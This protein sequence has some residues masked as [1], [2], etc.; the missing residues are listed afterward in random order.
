VFQVW[1]GYYRCEPF[2]S[3]WE[4][5][6]NLASLIHA[7]N[8]IAA[9]GKGVKMDTYSVSDF[10]PADSVPWRK[11]STVRKAGVRHPKIQSQIIKRAFGF[12]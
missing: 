2:G 6:A 11:R 10:L 9:A 3:H 8:C 12:G 4:Q 1:W 7:G 5:T